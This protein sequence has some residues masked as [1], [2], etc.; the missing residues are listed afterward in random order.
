MAA[1][2][3]NLPGHYPVYL[4]G[5][6]RCRCPAHQAQNNEKLRQ[7]RPHHGDPWHVASTPDHSN[8]D[9][10]DDTIDTILELLYG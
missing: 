9:E 2:H 4:E 8:E 3:S 6:H 10:H 7:T 5:S 1:P